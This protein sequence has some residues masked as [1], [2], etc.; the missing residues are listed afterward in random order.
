M[1]VLS[2]HITERDSFISSFLLTAQVYWSLFDGIYF[3]AKDGSSHFSISQVSISQIGPIWVTNSPLCQI[4]MSR[5]MWWYWPVYVT[6]SLITG[7]EPEIG[8]F[9]EKPMV[10]RR[11]EQFWTSWVAHKKKAVFPKGGRESTLNHLP[12][13]HLAK[14][15]IWISLSKSSGETEEGNFTP[16]QSANK[17]SLK[18]CTLCWEVSNWGSSYTKLQRQ[19]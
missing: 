2:K 17:T 4:I 8:S 13:L 5:Q 15:A 11:R 12:Q 14:G 1:S 6:C 7:W 19:N 18:T 3:L 9:R 10:E 16:A